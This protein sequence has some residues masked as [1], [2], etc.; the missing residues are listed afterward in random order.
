MINTAVLKERG[1]RP[2][3]HGNGFIQVD[4]TADTRLH[5][6]GDKRIPRQNVYTP[7]HDHVFGF[8]STIS[9]FSMETTASTCP[10]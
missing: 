5:V 3:V 1:V 2:R 9:V 10:R 8:E 4:L 7:I 6:W